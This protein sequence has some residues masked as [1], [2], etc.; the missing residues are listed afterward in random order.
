MVERKINT[1]LKIIAES[2]EPIGS[3]EISDRLKGFGIDLSER[4][5]RHHMQA[6]DEKGMTQ[7]KWKE[8]RVIT[9][10]G[11][12]E[13]HDA[14][15]SD[16]VGFISSRI[17]TMSYKMDFDLD[18]KTGNVILNIGF[19]PADKFTRAKKVMAEVFDHDETI[20][21]LVALAKEGESL[22]GVVVPSGKVAL[23]TLCSINLNAVLIKSGIPVESRFGGVLQIDNNQPIRFT[24]L[25]S[26]DGTT[27]DPV[28]VFIKSKMTNVRGVISS[29]TGRLMAGF[30]E[31]PAIAVGKAE[32]LLKKALELRLGSAWLI[33]KPGQ[34]LLGV[35]VGPE[36]VGLVFLAGL[37]P[38]AALEEAGIETQCKALTALVDYQQLKSFWDVN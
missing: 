6:L 2:K 25:I 34:P 28:E 14:F 7:G 17:E 24:D 38:V 9:E 16:K 23:G 12:Q 11:I 37:N 10:K 13:V 35:P 30:R 32:E 33:G 29:G 31:I 3:K 22:G 18:N 20:P 8:G 36:R 21:N 5:V 1:I 26:Y 19:I 15:V 4:T 27:L